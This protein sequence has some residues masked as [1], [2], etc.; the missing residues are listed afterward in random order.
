MADHE[1]TI[2]KLRQRVEGE[3]LQDG[4]EVEQ[5]TED[6]DFTDLEEA[7]TAK[8]S[9]REYVVLVN[10]GQAWKE[11]ARAEASSPVAAITAALGEKLEPNVEYVGIPIRSWQ[12]AS[13]EP[14]TTT[15]YKITRK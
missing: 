5:E 9:T 4:D 7:E 11:L 8:S 2:T 14:K 15:T 12:P 1:A 10:T 6:A 13:F 3:D